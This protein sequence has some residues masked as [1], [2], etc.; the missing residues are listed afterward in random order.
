MDVS[1]VEGFFGRQTRHEVRQNVV[2]ETL[3]LILSS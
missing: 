3:K 2:L 1:E